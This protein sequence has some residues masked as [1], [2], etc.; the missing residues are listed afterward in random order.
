MG[1]QWSTFVLVPPEC[2][3]GTPSKPVVALESRGGS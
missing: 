2:S 3:E 1:W